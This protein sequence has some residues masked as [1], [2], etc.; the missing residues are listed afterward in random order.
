[1]GLWMSNIEY[2]SERRLLP[3]EGCRILDIGSQNLYFAT[4]ETVRRFVL[5]HGRIAG[6][7][8]FLAEAERISY[9]STPR[10]GERT[11]Y[12]SELFDLTPDIFYTSYDVCPALKTEIFDL[13]VESCPAHYRG[14]FDCVLNFGTTEHIFNQTNSYRVMHDAL[15]VGGIAFHQVPGAG[16]IGHG[17]FTYQPPFFDDLVRSNEYELVDRWY[18]A[19]GQS[20]FDPSIEVRDPAR[21]QVPVGAAGEK[22]PL[23]ANY[24]L[25]VVL[26]KRIDA[27]FRVG[28]ELA[29]SHA[30]LSDEIAG[31]Y[32][33]GRITM[34]SG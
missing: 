31:R 29:T 5:R 28:L 26:R 2:L 16:W 13:N 8:A 3:A 24:N 4:P 22:L 27:P 34:A 17:Y 15:K 23:V 14:T 7:A 18:T 33:D 19:G 12:V 32:A 10:P 11:A 21:P 30:A 9:F 1:M 20:G 6:E 25:N